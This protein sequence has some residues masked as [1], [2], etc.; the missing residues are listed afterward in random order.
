MVKALVNGVVIAESDQTSMADDNHVS[1]ASH[2]DIDIGDGNVLSDAA[3]YYPKCITERAKDLA[4]RT[5]FYKNKV[6]I[7]E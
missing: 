6:Q 5:A 4:S 7:V 3:W 2:W 1:E